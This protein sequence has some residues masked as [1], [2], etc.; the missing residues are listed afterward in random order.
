MKMKNKF[1]RPLALLLSMIMLLTA[2]GQTAEKESS[3]STAQQTSSA[4]QSSAAAES[5]QET[6]ESEYPEYLNID[7]P[8]PIIKDEYADDITFTMVIG[9]QTNS[10]EWN[11][12]WIS[13]Y[14]SEKYNINLEV[15]YVTGETRDERKNLMFAANELPDIMI[16]C[17]ITTAELVKYGAEEG[18]FLQM[19]SYMNETLT[20]NILKY[21]VDDTKAVCTATDG[22]IYTLPYLQNTKESNY[23]VPA[24]MFIN[25]KWLQDLGLEKPKTL[26]EFVDVLYAIKEADP[27][28]VGSENLYPMGGGMDTGN[29]SWFLLN[30]MGYITYQND[31]YGLNPTLRDGEVAIPAYDMDIFKE[32]LALMNQFYTDGIITPT[33]FT[34]DN[35][36]INAYM[37]NGQ[38]AMYANAPYLPGNEDWADYE[39]LSPLTSEWQTEP[40]IAALTPASIGG[41]VISADTEY[42]EL[43]MRLADAFFNNTDDYCA[44]LYGGYGI[45]SE[46]SFGYLQKE[47]LAESNSFAVDSSKTPDNISSWHYIVGYLNGNTW[48]IG[49][50][51]MPESVERL[52]ALQGHP[53]YKE[54]LDTSG[55][56]IWRTSVEENM[57]PYVAEGYPTVLYAATEVNEQIA[58]LESVIEP[59]AKEQIALFITGKRPLS[60]VDA[61]K[62][63]LKNLGMEDLLTIY[64]DMYASYKQ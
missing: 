28:G 12:L 60:E 56:N 38:T 13:K 55:K 4:S 54:K 59:Y 44:A 48:E 37:N 26:D 46:W 52:A 31:P 22:H 21:M 15:E 40:E 64:T 27:A 42:P 9:M 43:C 7:S 14:L 16:N 39:C 61:F 30:A 58:D 19:D 8:Y 23:N 45:D 41:F 11:D 63:E 17:Q 20:P 50:I 2:C 18:L 5:T 53:D 51:L 10:G 6:A 29:I 34:I 24:R 49:A 32:Y 57:M 33:Y 36:E 1:M 25:N 47:Y 35:T 3:A 62:E